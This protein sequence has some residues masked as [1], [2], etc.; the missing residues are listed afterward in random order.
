MKRILWLLP[1]LFLFALVMPS[2]AQSAT[3]EA[4]PSV[5][6]LDWI[7][8][9]FSGFVTVDMSN[10]QSTLGTLNL[11]LFTASVLQP[12]RIRYSQAQNFDPFFPLTAFDM[13]NASFTQ[14]V[15]PWLDN[16]VIIAYRNLGTDFNANATNTMMIFPATDAL[17]AAN[18]LNAVIKAQDF[19][20]RETYHDV[21]L[22]EGDKTSF[23]FLAA[24]VISGPTA[25]LRETID[26]M[27]GNGHALTADPVYQQVRAALPPK[28]VLSAYLAKDAAAHALGVLMSGGSTADPIL[29]AINESL[30]SL[31]GDKT[32]ER[33]L[34]SGSLD[35]IGISVAA[36]TLHTSTV[37][38]NIVLHTVDT[39]DATDTKFDPAVL[40]LIPRSAMIVQS[41][42]DAS[43]TATDA[44]YSLPFLNF[45]GKALA[46]FPV[47]QPS[48]Q[49]LSVPTAQDAQ[50]A[51]SG[52]LSALKSTVDVQSD[53]IDK[54]KGSYSLALLPRPNDPMPILNTPYD[55]LLVVKTDS[56]SAAQAAQTSA[57]KLLAAFT[58]PLVSEQ[59]DAQTFQTLRA[60][61]TGES[62]VSVGAV[63]NLF[64][65]GTGSAAQ[66]AVDAMHGDNR[67]TKQDRWMNLSRNND[68]P[69]VYVDV[70]AFYN[71][72]LPTIGGP[73]VRPVSQF[74]IH[75]RYL[76]SNLFELN[77]QV[78]LSQ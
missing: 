47:D 42:T 43:S 28:T 36:D 9:D 26:T 12:T 46:A 14:N 13:E 15:L 52:F 29:T 22:Y 1:I 72:F 8:A 27:T 34:L 60:P 40:D 17:E 38:A 63:D 62:L 4:A 31:N 23:A 3:Q 7:P 78:A 59:L 57:T 19:L 48:G 41:G 44:L 76:G 35:G 61:D 58:S 30:A 5:S 39:P 69:Y 18:A 56:P 75:S 53:L 71:T 65:I 33:L 32:P 55:L 70:N 54:L 64:V 25:L 66:L 37:T 51:V 2:A 20:K 10:S 11:T 16:Q 77:M 67:L 21:I 50:T 73:A 74:G 49:S 45:A 24:A 6:P 68:I